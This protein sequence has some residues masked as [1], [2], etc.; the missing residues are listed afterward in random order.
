M[1]KE[2]IKVKVE[3]VLEIS[4]DEYDNPETMMEEISSN[5][6]YDFPS[7]ENV[8]V[9]DTEWRDTQILN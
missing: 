5:C 7:T 6:M 2:N 3:I 1:A 8:T 4:S 9:H